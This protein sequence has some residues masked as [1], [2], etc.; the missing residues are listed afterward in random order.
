MCVML[1]VVAIIAVCVTIPN[2]I[3]NNYIR[4]AHLTLIQ[5]NF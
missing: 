5:M 3:D 2:M 1:L 4:E